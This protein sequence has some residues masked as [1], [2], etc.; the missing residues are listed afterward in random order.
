MIDEK[1]TNLLKANNSLSL[2]ECL[3]L[4]AVQKH[5]PITKEVAK[6]LHEKG[7][8]EG[9]A[10]HYT[11]S[12]KVAQMTKQIGHYTKENGLAKNSIQKLLL[13]LAHNAGSMGFKRQDV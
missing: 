11:I 12:L 9:R 5:L 6:H 13:Q 10:P 7:L 4:D 1:Y 3:W 2:K 8:I